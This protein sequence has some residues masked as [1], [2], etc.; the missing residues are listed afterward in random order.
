MIK[1]GFEYE[2]LSSCLKRFP[3]VEASGCQKNNKHKESSLLLGMPIYSV[4]L[5]YKSEPWGSF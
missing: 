3:K 2:P 4:G 1:N 5:V